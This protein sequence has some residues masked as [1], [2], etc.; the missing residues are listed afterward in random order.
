M[1]VLTSCGHRY[2]RSYQVIITRGLLMA[3]CMAH[4]HII[5]VRVSAAQFMP[6][7]KFK[8]KEGKLLIRISKSEMEYLVSH[9]VKYSENG[10]ISTTGHHKSWYMTENDRCMKLLNECRKSHAVEK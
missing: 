9:G 10:I 5:R 1:A 3:G 4:D 8:T 2:L 7:G 6:T